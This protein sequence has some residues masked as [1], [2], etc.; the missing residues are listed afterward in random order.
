MFIKNGG[1]VQARQAFK[2]RCDRI[3]SGTGTPP[4]GLLASSELGTD[5]DWIQAVGHVEEADDAHPWRFADSIEALFSF[6]QR[7]VLFLVMTL[8]GN[9]HHTVHLLLHSL[10]ACGGRELRRGWECRGRWTPRGR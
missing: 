2:Y 1:G 7:V 5:W 10:I 4:V 9:P 6:L 3:L 8:D